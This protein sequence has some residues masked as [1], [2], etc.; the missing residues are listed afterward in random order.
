MAPAS[1]GDH[2]RT[3][4]DAFGHHGDLEGRGD[5]VE[6]GNGDRSD[7]GAVQNRLESSL[8]NLDNYEQNLSAA[9][10]QIRD[11]DFAK[12]ASDMA[13]YQVMQ[14]AGV[15]ALAQAKSINQQAAQLI[16]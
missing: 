13:K 4:I 8:S 5:E 11:A 10:S 6:A 14:Q 9:E 1:A 12:E 7:Y 15:A 2:D 16:Q 3:T